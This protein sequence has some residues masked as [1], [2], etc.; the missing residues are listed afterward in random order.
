MTRLFAFSVARKLFQHA[1]SERYPTRSVEYLLAWVMIAWGARVVWPGEVLTGPTYQYLVVIAPEA[2]WGALGITVGLLR[3]YA[4]L[5]NGGW[6][7]S[8][9]LRFAGATLGLIWWLVLAVLFSAAVAGGAPDFP[10]RAVYPVFI[11]FEAY[12]CFRCGQDH[13]AVAQKSKLEC[14]AHPA[15]KDAGNG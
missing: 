11:F 5:R 13:A 8:P 14:P 7:R 3:I 1:A 2:M 15:Q 4:L 6:K 12:S 9:V 10:M